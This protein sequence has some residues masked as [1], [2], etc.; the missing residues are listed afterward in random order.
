M[1]ARGSRAPFGGTFDRRGLFRR[2]SDTLFAGFEGAVERRHD[3]P[4]TTPSGGAS[5]GGV[6]SCLGVSCAVTSCSGCACGGNLFHCTGC[7]DDFFGCYAGRDCA[8]FC[9]RPI[10]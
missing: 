7:G 3:E 6:V 8:D 1:R 5:P 2:A 4:R 9:L 10:C